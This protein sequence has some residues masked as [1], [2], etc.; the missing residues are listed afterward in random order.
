MSRVFIKSSFLAACLPLFASL[1]IFSLLPARLSAQTAASLD[2]V[3]KIYVEPF[4]GKRGAQEI[5]EEFVDRLKHDPRLSVVANPSQSDAVLKGNGEIWATGHIATNPRAAS[6]NRSP[7]YSGYLSL[8]VEGRN[9]QPLW[10]Y[11]VTPSGPL[12]GGITASLAGHGVKLLDAAIGHEKRTAA[13]G[14]APLTVLPNPA[15]QTTLDGAGG[16]FPAPLY[17]AWI[18]SFHQ[19]HPEIEVSYSAV[20]SEQGIQRLLDGKSNFA[21]SDAPVS[22]DRANLQHFATVL[23]AIVP[24]YNVAGLDRS[25]R[26]TP[27]ILAGIYLGN[28]SRWDDP[29]IRAAN[30]GSKFPH[31]QIAVVHRSDGSGTT[32]AFTDY[33]TKTVPAW[34]SVG[35][36]T[37]V[38]WPVGIGFAGNDGVATSVQ[39]TPNSIG[40]V[41]LTF[42][43]QRELSFGAVRNRAGNFV[44]ASLESVAAAAKSA[45]PLP[46]AAMRSIVDAPGKDA[47][48]IAS[49]T[50]ILLPMPVPAK[51]RSP[52]IQFLQ[53]MLTSGQ[54][55]S[56]SLGYAPLPRELADRELQSFVQLK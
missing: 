7:V 49:F 45:A 1:A 31:A 38:P 16:T 41:E 34:K 37:T 55:Q 23:G 22:P 28:I 52:L 18:G 54:K 10:S 3:K 48:P 21:A 39:R 47:Y 26:F 44:S 6:S 4:T 56:S 9:A 14:S 42:A 2:E 15:L 12:S 24:I 40:Y 46:S 11:L 50:W 17:Q 25:L 20:G 29:L 19:L 32:Y 33:L 13:S 43:I 8:T 30:Q 5:R 36:G 35:T 53:W 51:D 27:E